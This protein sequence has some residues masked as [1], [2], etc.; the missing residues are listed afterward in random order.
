VM[1]LGVLWCTV[2]RDIAGYGCAVVCCLVLCCVWVCRVVSR[3]SKHMKLCHELSIFACALVGI[4][5]IKAFGSEQG[6][7]Y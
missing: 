7:R 3:D 4:A 5:T 6:R 2:R 1:L